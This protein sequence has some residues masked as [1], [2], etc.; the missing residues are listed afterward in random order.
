M[1]VENR[2]HKRFAFPKSSR[3]RA[4]LMPI[5]GGKSV[6]ATILNVS[7]GGV[8]LAAD[9]RI[10]GIVAEDKEMFFQNVTEGTGLPCLKGEKVRIKWILN[11]EPLENLGIGCEFVGLKEECLSQLNALFHDEE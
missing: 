8:G 9:K 3:I 2:K 5:S 11:Y 6:E 4:T 7:Q 10:N 1:T